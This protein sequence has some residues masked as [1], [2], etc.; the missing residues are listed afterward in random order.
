MSKQRIV[1]D[2]SIK[3]LLSSSEIMPDSIDIKGRKYFPKDP[4]ST[5]GFK[6]V[7]W[8]GVDE[9]DDP[10]AIKFAIY[11]DYMKDSYLDEANKAA[12][13]RGYSQFARFIDAELIE[14]PLPEKPVTK[15]VCFI[16]ELID[17]TT[18]DNYVKDNEISPSFIKN[19][20]IGMCNALN[21][22]RDLD[23]RHD[24]LHCKNVMIAPPKKGELR[25]EYVLKIIDMGSLKS[26]DD[27]LTKDKDDHGNFIDHLVFLFNSMCFSSINKRRPLCLNQRRYRKE[28][29]PLI[30]SMLEEDRQIALFDPSEIETK[31]EHAFVR[32][33]HRDNEL[34]STLDDPFDYISAEHI[35]SDKLLIDLFAES[36]PW[37]KEVTSPNPLLLTGPRGC[38][39]SMLFRRVSLKALH[40]KTEDDIRKSRIIGFYISCSADIANRI[41]RIVSVPKAVR[42]KNEIIHYFNLLLTLE[43]VQAL[44]IVSNRFDRES[45]FGFGKIQEKELHSFL[46]NK[47]KIINDRKLRL[48]GVTPLEHISEIIEFEMSYCCEQ[49]LQGRNLEASLPISFLTDLTKFLKNEIGYFKDRTVTF[50]LDDFSIHRISEPVQAVLKP[51]IWERQSTHIFKL[52]SETFGSERV[53]EADSESSATADLTREYREI[54]CGRFYIDLSDRELQSDL[55]R[56]TKEL[57]DHRLELAGYS[58]SSDIIIGPST[59]EKSTLGK[60]LRFLK[61]NHNQYH[62]LETIAEICSGDISAL[63]EVFRIIFN[64]GKV[65]KETISI[66]PKELQ[67]KAICSVSK[68]FLE[69]IK[70]FHPYGE[71]MDRIVKSF[72]TLCRKILVDGKIMSDGRLCET[73]RIEVDQ[74]PDKPDE[75]WTNEQKGIMKELIRRAVFIEMEASRGR[76]TLGPTFRWQLRRIYCSAFGASLRKSIA[77][78]WN[79]SDLKYFITNPEDK[80]KNEFQTRW[81]EGMPKEAKKETGQTYFTLESEI[82]NG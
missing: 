3:K 10:V 43:I 71:D 74:I 22:L 39:K 36:C 12:R 79:T 33:E 70:S 14:I 78:K 19:Y 81:R 53:I 6:S 68:K 73:T 75:D 72:G 11:D 31:F 66:V 35:A 63:L 45:L 61:D 37:V 59:Y 76:R 55:I 82:D 1:M 65:N 15:F 4:I 38:G 40:Y 23:F 69:L 26:Y 17:G 32:S 16:E 47:L 29:I 13:L 21:I 34:E 51:L 80:C 28:I 42:F 48:Q 60:E 62:G 24:D 41:G 49:I 67:H 64:R 44:F 46:L 52:S 58:G 54:D 57:L 18:L 7:V 20:T 30:N 2:D 77:V 56:F 8:Q 5:E 27:P 50:L 25:D 9:Y